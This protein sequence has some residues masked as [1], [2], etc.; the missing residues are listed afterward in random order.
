MMA[1]WLN[2]KSGA[3]SLHSGKDLTNVSKVA[4]TVPK[5]AGNSPT[6]RASRKS[7]WCFW[8]LHLPKRKAPRRGA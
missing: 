7:P 2:G 5:R 6:T 1:W 3:G 8:K 4:L